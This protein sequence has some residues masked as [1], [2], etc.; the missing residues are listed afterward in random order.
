MQIARAMVTA[1]QY[2]IL[3][4]EGILKEAPMKTNHRNKNSTHTR[5]QIVD[6]TGLPGSGKSYLA[7][8]LYHSLAR[9]GIETRNPLGSITRLPLCKRLPLKVAF[10]MYFIT[11]SPVHAGE[12][13]RL[14]RVFRQRTV[15]DTCGSLLNLLFVF[16]V[17][18]YY[19]Q[20]PIVLILD[21]GVMQAAASVLYAVKGFQERHIHQLSWVPL[22]TVLVE[23]RCDLSTLFARLRS[24]TVRQSRVEKEPRE[25]LE[26]TRRC[27]RLVTH[28]RWYQAIPRHIQLEST[29]TTTSSEPWKQLIALLTPEKPAR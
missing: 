13:L 15:R 9:Q 11:T 18:A 17:I 27:L 6:F 25:G 23:V 2:K 16:G 14:L 1:T 24:R 29:P 8:E 21:Q 22:P 5:C 4:P 12:T 19:R 3:L 28:S 7:E 10:A 26:R 20:K